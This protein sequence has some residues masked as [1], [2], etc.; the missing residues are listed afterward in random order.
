LQQSSPDGDARFVRDTATEEPEPRTLLPSHALPFYVNYRNRNV[1][2]SE[3][4]LLPPHGLLFID[5]NHKVSR[6]AGK[7]LLRQWGI[8]IKLWRGQAL[9]A[10]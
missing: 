4:F 9:L 6:E 7:L 2:V 10:G 1:G 5:G 3:R 8:D